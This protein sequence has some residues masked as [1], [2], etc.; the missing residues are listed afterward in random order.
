MNTQNSGAKGKKYTPHCSLL[1]PIAEIIIEGLPEGR[2]GEEIPDQLTLV[3][4]IK[5][6]YVGIF[7]LDEDGNDLYGQRF[8]EGKKYLAQ[9]T[10]FLP[11]M[12]NFSEDVSLII[13]GKT[14][15]PEEFDSD[16]VEINL[17][18]EYQITS[19]SEALGAEAAETAVLEPVD[20]MQDGTVPQDTVSQE[21]LQ[22]EM[23]QEAIAE[24]KNSSDQHVVLLCC[25][26]GFLALYGTSKMLKKRKNEKKLKGN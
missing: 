26:L 20:T 8:Q 4:N 14:Y 16:M 24:Q 10:V 3:S 25:A 18:I 13:D 23:V 19:P 12:Y 9:V 11:S 15:S 1:A 21:S 22:I 5:D 7:W 6:C 2:V 17:E